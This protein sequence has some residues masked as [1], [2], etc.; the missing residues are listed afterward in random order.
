M[1][2]PFLK[3]K[4]ALVT[5]GLGAIGEAIS[6]ELAA[7]G[8]SVAVPGRRAELSSEVMAYIEAAAAP[9]DAK[10]VYARGDMKDRVSLAA[11]VQTVQ[12]ELGRIDAL[13]NC[14]GV[15]HISSADELAVED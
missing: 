12:V 13:V 11:V 15:Q 7:V 5:G 1:Y 10:V 4:T 14:A 8:C 6:T 3:G 9:H 2:Q